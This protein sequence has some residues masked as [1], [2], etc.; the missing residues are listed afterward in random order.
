MMQ[1]QYCCTHNDLLVYWYLSYQVLVQRSDA[2]LLTA[3]VLF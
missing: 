3:V 2:P 1:Q